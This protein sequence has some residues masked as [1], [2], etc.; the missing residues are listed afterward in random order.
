M[1]AGPDLGGWDSPYPYVI[2][3]LA[4]QGYINSRAFSMD[5]K[6]IDS[7]A[8]SVIYGGIDT[9]KYSGNLIKLPIVPA[10]QS[11]DG[12]T[13]L[14][15]RLDGISVNQADGTVVN[16]YTTPAGGVGQTVL[17]DSGYTLSALPTAIF[18]NL[19]AAFPS[20]V[21][22]PTADLYTVDCLDRGQGGSLDFTFDGQV[23]NV[24]YYDFVW[25]NPDNGLCYLGAYEDSK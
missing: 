12:Y 7:T 21:Y 2:D 13:R 11:P 23:I 24:P 20:A 3:S 9:Y 4:Q 18:N 15:V 8:G 17:L 5:L 10:A 14:Y 6:G 25:H 16:V 22:D 1:G 19:V